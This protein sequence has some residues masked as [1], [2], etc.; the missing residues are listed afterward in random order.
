MLV[1]LQ[2]RC[3]FY[4]FIH[5]SHGYAS[6]PDAAERETN[7]EQKRTCYG[8]DISVDASDDGG[9]IAAQQN[10]VSTS[11]SYHQAQ[12]GSGPAAFHDR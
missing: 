6:R 4:L 9:R 7:R 1:T 10:P 3:L 5:L 2:M 8:G 12:S 11:L